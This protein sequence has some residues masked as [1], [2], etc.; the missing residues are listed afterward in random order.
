MS[1]WL[2][3]GFNNEPRDWSNLNIQ[4]VASLDV[5]TVPH[6]ILDAYSRLC[7]TNAVVIMESGEWKQT[8][9][10]NKMCQEAKKMLNQPQTGFMKFLS[11]QRNEII[12]LAKSETYKDTLEGKLFASFEKY[13]YVDF[14]QDPPE[15]QQ[16]YRDASASD[17]L[18]MK[19]K[20][21]TQIKMEDK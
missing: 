13:I 7:D 10:A 9:R 11:E 2:Y 12:N 18:W 17:K 3:H 6:T 4:T 21:D 14:S 16:V 15:M 8:K 19:F 1:H 5:P 20:H